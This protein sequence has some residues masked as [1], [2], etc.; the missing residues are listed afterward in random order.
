MN[1]ITPSATGAATRFTRFQVQRCIRIVNH[2][3]EYL[4]PID[5]RQDEWT[6][7]PIK[8]ATVSLHCSMP[9]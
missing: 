1:P 4:L 3:G 8:S 9:T 7:E 5:A 2:H 6:L